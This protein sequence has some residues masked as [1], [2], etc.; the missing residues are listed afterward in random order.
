[1][2]NLIN[3]TAMICLSTLVF[4]AIVIGL[5]RLQPD[6]APALISGVGPLQWAGLL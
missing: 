2:R 4:C 3:L 6:P 1:M 5:G